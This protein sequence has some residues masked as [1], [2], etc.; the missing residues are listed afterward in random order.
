LTIRDTASERVTAEVEPTRAHT[1][2]ASASTTPDAAEHSARD[3][4]TWPS[5]RALWWAVGGLLLS[6]V[7]Y[8][9]A[10]IMFDPFARVTFS[11]GELYERAAR[12]VLAHPF[13][14]SQPLYL[15]GLYAYLLAAGIGPTGSVVGGLILQLIAAGAGLLAFGAA[16]RSCFGPRS[17][18]LSLI[19]LLAVFDLAFYENKYLSV[20]LGI[21]ACMF[22]VWAAVRAAARPSLARM[23]TWG[24]CLG[25]AVLGRGNLL[26]ALP[27]CLLGVW[28]VSRGRAVAQPR[29]LDAGVRNVLA[30][31]F[32]CALAL[33]P[34]ALRNS[35]VTGELSV[36]PSHAGG[37]P[38]YIGNNPH[39]N[40]RWNT[41]GG[42]LT[43]QVANERHELVRRLGLDAQSPHLDAAIGAE[44]YRRAF[45]FIR[46]E[47][48][49]WLGLEAEKLWDTLGN[50][51]F[52][53]DYDR[54]GERELLGLAQPVGLPFGV[55]LGLGVL[56]LGALLSEARA[57]PARAA[58][59]CTLVSLLGACLAANLV[60]FTSA[61][62][63]APLIV[64][65]AFAAGPAIT[66]LLQHLRGHAPLQRSPALLWLAALSAVQAFYPRIAEQQHPSSTHYYNLANV[67][68][69]LGQSGAALAHYAR[70][71]ELSPRQP[72]FWW[73]RAYLAQR[74]Q[75]WDEARLAL[76]HLTV[77]PDLPPELARAAQSVRAKLPTTEP[78]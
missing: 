45:T 9:I 34:M 21:S 29:P 46:A 60:W 62:N 20:S 52:V 22:V 16:A 65:L 36:F 48:V 73:R 47:P 58:V 32:G 55:L 54:L 40:G 56:G 67:E 66:A 41:A 1:A 43:G 63:R 12:D 28:L 17:G 35:H 8:H 7:V 5:T 57:D 37:I 49:R 10:Y 18:L 39:A 75:R 3:G 51:A 30:L 13:W 6:R 14:G 4:D 68:E 2:S 74:L 77:L 50:H 38:F 44:L 69:E 19:A 24:A 23:A 25:V 78:Q 27:G 15:Q 61:Q 64:P 11:D 26:L 42:L 76:E 31:L 70:A 53:R 71:S 72:M 59:S 33:L